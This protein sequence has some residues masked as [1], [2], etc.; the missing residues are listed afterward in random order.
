[1]IGR[2]KR[3]ELP[4]EPETADVQLPGYRLQRLLGASSRYEVFQAWSEERS[5]AV[6]VKLARPSAG[7]IAGERLLDEGRIL[8][9]LTHPNLL[10][11]YEV[12]DDPAAALVVELLA[13]PTI[14]DLFDVHGWLPYADV[15]EMG[16]QV[17]AGIG[18]L[19]R[20]G[21]VHGDLKPGNV[22]AEHGRAT[23]IDLGLARPPGRYERPYGTQGYLSP[24]QAACQPVDAAADVWGLGVLLLES[25]SGRDAFPPGCKEYREAYGPVAAPPPRPFPQGMPAEFTELILKCT[26]FEPAVR[27][28]LRDVFARLYALADATRGNKRQRGLWKLSSR[29]VT[30][31]R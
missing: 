5:V 27:P 12:H 2:A 18:Y 11:L 17:A 1:M 15:V 26:A 8:A 29:S 31:R 13:G 6:A 7:E 20:A 28:A 24:E 3:P 30:P 19:H 4:A 25:A 9:E 21:W 10:R 23:V 16:R 14:A 22:I